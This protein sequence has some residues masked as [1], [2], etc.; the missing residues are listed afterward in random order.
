MNLGSIAKN[1]HVNL[2][3]NE[4]ARFELLFWSAQ[5][6]ILQVE[7]KK[8]QVPDEWLVIIVPEYFEISK[9]TGNQ[10]I[11]VPGIRNYIKATPVSIV[12]KPPPDESRGKYEIILDAVAGSGNNGLSFF[13]TAAF[14]LT[15]NIGPGGDQ[16]FAES[17]KEISSEAVQENNTAPFFEETRENEE[18][19]LIYYELLII[20][21]IALLIYKFS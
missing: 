4:S 5:D 2:I 3:N 20:I 12:V 15:V 11:F 21:I 14:K 18:I 13:P 7:I 19:N 1:N 6:E 10:Y 8:K 9:S 17:S 16:A